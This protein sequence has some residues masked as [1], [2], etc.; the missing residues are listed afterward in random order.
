MNAISLLCFAHRHLSERAVSNVE[1]KADRC[2]CY[3]LGVRLPKRNN[4]PTSFREPVLT[5]HNHLA[6]SE[7]PRRPGPQKSSHSSAEC[8]ATCTERVWPRP[9]RAG[10]ISASAMRLRDISYRH[11]FSDGLSSAWACR[12]C[13][14]AR[15]G[16]STRRPWWWRLDPPRRASC[17]E[18]TSEAMPP[19]EKKCQKEKGCHVGVGYL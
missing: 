7:R 2:R 12:R 16:E 9:K 8:K 1:L 4:S 10:A 5:G 6:Q 11:E 15:L 3:P 18:R 17:G 13:L 19:A 14:P